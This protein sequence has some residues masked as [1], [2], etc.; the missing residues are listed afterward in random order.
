MATMPSQLVTSNCIAMK[1][2]H[3]LYQGFHSSCLDSQWCPISNKWEGAGVVLTH[4]GAP[5]HTV[6]IEAYNPMES[7]TSL[8][9]KSEST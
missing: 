4:N 9:G 1:N 8:S 3:F 5:V 2:D 6:N 7:V